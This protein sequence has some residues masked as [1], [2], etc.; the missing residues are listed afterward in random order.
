MIISE[1]DR[2]HYEQF[3]L[4]HPQ[5][6]LWQSWKWGN[7]QESLG[8][9]VFRV[10]SEGEIKASAQ[11]IKHTLPFGKSYFYIPRG[12]LWAEEEKLEQLWEEVALLA[13]KEKAVF[14]KV[15]PFI[16]APLPKKWL[17][18]NGLYLLTEFNQ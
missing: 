17:I 3:V 10:V 9:K 8:R 5:G 2:E 15:D 12:P 13:R 18:K 6:N 4:S 14:T 7:F 11:I 16:E 1:N